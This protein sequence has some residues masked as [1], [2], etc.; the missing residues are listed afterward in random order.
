MSPN[1]QTRAISWD[2]WGTLRTLS[3]SVPVVQ[4]L[5]LCD[6]LASPPKT[7]LSSLCLA[8]LT[9]YNEFSFWDPLE[10]SKANGEMMYFS[11]SL[12]SHVML[13]REREELAGGSVVFHSQE[14][15]KHGFA[16]SGKQWYS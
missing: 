12:R 1:F 9:E 8:A 13:F 7:D 16:A 11:V 5:L 6:H 15:T 2:A 4:G 3:L 14:V 10:Q